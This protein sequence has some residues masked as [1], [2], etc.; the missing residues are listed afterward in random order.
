MRRPLVD[1]PLVDPPWFDIRTE[2][3]RAWELWTLEDPPPFGP[4]RTP[5]W[6]APAFSQAKTQGRVVKDLGRAA[7]HR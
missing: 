3:E 5:A 2:E 6:A 7:S 4:S 1:P